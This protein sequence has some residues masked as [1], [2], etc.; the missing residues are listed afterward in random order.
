[1]DKSPILR[2][3]DEPPSHAKEVPRLSKESSAGAGN[4][5]NM[6]HKFS[7]AMV[8]WCMAGQRRS[9]IGGL[10]LWYLHS[11]RSGRCRSILD[12]HI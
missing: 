9:I 7:S 12:A 3:E 4:T 5:G 10:S 1:M 2:C 11:H 8:Q 6:A